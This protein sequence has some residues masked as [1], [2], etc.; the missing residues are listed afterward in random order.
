MAEQKKGSKSE[1]AERPESAVADYGVPEN[2]GFENVGVD[3]I[4]L[5]RLNVLQALSPQVNAKPDEGG[6][7]GAKAGMLHNSVTDELYDGDKG[8]VFVPAYTTH[9]F[10]EKVPRKRGGGFVGRHE[11]D[12]EV[13]AKAKANKPANTKFGQY[14]TDYAKNDDG[15]F[16]GNELVETFELYGV[17]FREE[18]PLP[19]VLT[20]T[21][22]K[23]KVYRNWMMSVKAFRPK[24]NIPLFAHRVLITTVGQKH[25]EGSSYNIRMQPALKDEDGKRTLT[26]SLLVPGQEDV[27][28]GSHDDLLALG[29]EVYEMAKEGRAR[30]SYESGEG[31]ASGGGAGTAGEGEGGDPPF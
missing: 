13:V 24:Q 4:V 28:F 14:S 2:A 5:P 8:V 6:L 12:S 19:A 25:A 27:D 17:L 1:V 16:K 26:A 15:T 3:D 31:E 20:I 9:L 21:S 11:L 29:K 22:T 7:E 30:A 10:I 23:I 18:G